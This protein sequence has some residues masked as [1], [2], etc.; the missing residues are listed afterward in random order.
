MPTQVDITSAALIHIGM[1]PINALDQATPRATAA[2]AIFQKTVDE[3]LY[4]HSWKFAMTQAVLA[5][6]STTPA[7]RY[8]S[9]FA[10]PAD[11]YCLKVWLTSEDQAFSLVDFEDRWGTP[12]VEGFDQGR[13]RWEV[14]GRFILANCDTL[15]IDYVARITDPGQFDP[16]FVTTL[17]YKLASKLAGPLT[18]KWPVGDAMR[19]IYEIE[20]ARA[21]GSD[22]QQRSPRRA[23]SITYLRV[24]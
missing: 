11:P 10:L 24:R 20:L 12:F 17:E 8:D 23:P 21:K 22:S 2:L 13:G 7:F 4:E 14:Q 18:G 3:I 1:Q 6:T 5:K 16:G 9:Q 15:T 19:K